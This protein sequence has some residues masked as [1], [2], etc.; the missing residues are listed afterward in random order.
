[1]E[2]AFNRGA[3]QELLER[4]I[5]N[6]NGKLSIVCH[7][8][9]PSSTVKIACKIMLLNSLKQIILRKMKQ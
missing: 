8:I 1:M 6:M 5:K 3:L 9:I 4:N 2:I 7:F